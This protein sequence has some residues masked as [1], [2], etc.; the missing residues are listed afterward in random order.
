VLTYSFPLLNAA[1]G[2]AGTFWTYAGVCLAG[3]VYLSMR[4]PETKGRTLEQLERDFVTRQ[5][6]ADADKVQP[7]H[8]N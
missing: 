4:L 8:G 1:L 5:E 7:V 3:A 6:N 2:A